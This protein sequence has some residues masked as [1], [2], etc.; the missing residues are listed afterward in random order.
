MKW[1]TNPCSWHAMRDQRG[2]AAVLV[3][4]SMT[5]FLGFA[6]VSVDAGYLYTVWA[7]LQNSTQAAALAGASDIGVGGSPIATAIKYSS[8]TATPANRN[9]IPG[10]TTAMTT[11]YPALQCF[12]GASDRG[13]ACSTNHTPGTSA[14][15]ILVQQAATVPLFF[16]RIFGAPS[17]TVTASAVALAAGQSPGPLN[18][19]FVLDTTASMGSND[20]SCGTTRLKCAIDGFKILLGKLWPCK[21]DLASCGPATGHNVADPVDKAGLI[22]FPG[23]KAAPTGADC[24]SLTTVP[25]AGVTAKTSARTTTS[26]YTLNFSQTPSAFTTG[27]QALVTNVTNPTSIPVGTYVTTL[28]SSTVTMSRAP[29]ATVASGDTIAVWPPVYQIMPLSS[30]YRTSDTA[31]SLNSGSDLVGCVNTIKA[32]GGF[33]TFYADAITTA[34]QTLLAN[35][36]EGARN[37]IILLGDGE[38]NASASTMVSGR[39]VSNQCKLAVTAAQNAAKAGTWV[40]AISYGSSNGGCTTDASSYSNACYAMSQ[41]ANMP[42]TTAGTYT[43]DPTK[44]YADNA[45]GC[46]ST[47]H[48]NITSLSAIFQSIHYSLTTPR[49]LPMA[50]FSKTPPASC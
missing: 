29:T 47:A 50:C 31:T 41:I 18:V 24:S 42:G 33:G 5:A 46:K 43:T 38:A 36:R 23:V 6:A 21:Y 4:V 19:M 7:Q 11:G 35:T 16:G 2:S 8:V 10:V 14:N 30:D 40:Y 13:L 32:P 45:N 12:K 9:P 28:G 15:G 37:V 39:S 49:L 44:F 20:S 17:V 1:Q 27:A 22:T 34:Q 26:S 3:G 25:Y 48:P